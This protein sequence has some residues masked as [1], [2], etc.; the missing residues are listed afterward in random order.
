[1]R[2]Q[3]FMSL[4]AHDVHLRFKGRGLTTCCMFEGSS[5]T[6]LDGAEASSSIG[7]CIICELDSL[8]LTLKFNSIYLYYSQA[9]HY[10][11][12]PAISLVLIHNS[13]NLIGCLGCLIQPD[14][15]FGFPDLT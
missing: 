9:R 14:G 4:F 12:I 10:G 5:P 11:V 8:S 3:F 13:S 15:L 6:R 2:Q 7:D 1:M